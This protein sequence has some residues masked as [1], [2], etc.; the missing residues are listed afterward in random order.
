MSTNL[1][2]AQIDEHFIPLLRRLSTGDWFTSRTSACALFAAAYPNAAPEAQEE[3]RRLFAALV[4]DDTPM[5]RRAAARALGVSL[6]AGST[7]TLAV[8]ESRRLGSRPA[9][10]HH[11]RPYSPVPP[12]GGRRPGLCSSSYH[13]RPHCVW[14]QPVPR[15]DQGPAARVA[16]CERSGQELACA[17]HGCQRVCRAGRER[18]T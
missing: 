15:G 9:R 6:C 17:L 7:D 14:V 5:V 13:S 12:P 1:T 3:M 16:S 18:R 11:L 10:S 2:S 4:A 8:C